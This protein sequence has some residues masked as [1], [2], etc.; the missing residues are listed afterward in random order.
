MRKPKP[1]QKDRFIK[2][3]DRHPVTGKLIDDIKPWQDAEGNWLPTEFDKETKKFKV[4]L[5]K[6]ASADASK[7]AKKESESK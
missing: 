3:T 5:S 1:K 7:D 6:S 2:Q 4:I